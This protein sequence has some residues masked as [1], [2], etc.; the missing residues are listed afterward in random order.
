M[1]RTQ[2]LQLGRARHLLAHLMAVLALWGAPLEAQADTFFFPGFFL[3]EG[4]S[5]DFHREFAEA[6]ERPRGIAPV[7]F[8][9]T[10]DIVL[11]VGE[12][13]LVPVF[14]QTAE[15]LPV[16][17]RWTLE[18]NI[19]RSV[20]STIDKARPHALNGVTLSSHGFR[21]LLPSEI[22]GPRADTP[23]SAG[24]GCERRYFLSNGTHFY[25]GHH[26]RAVR[27]SRADASA[28]LCLHG[29]APG[30]GQV[31][32]G[33]SVLAQDLDRRV[34]GETDLLRPP[35]LGRD[36]RAAIRVK[37][38]EAAGGV[39][40]DEM[41]MAEAVTDQ[42][43]LNACRIRAVPL[44]RGG[45][46]L[47]CQSG[48]FEVEWQYSTSHYDVVGQPGCTI[49]LTPKFLPPGT[50]RAFP[51]G[52]Q[53]NAVVSQVEERVIS[54]ATGPATTVKT[55]KQA[56]AS[57]YLHPLAEIETERVKWARAICPPVVVPGGTFSCLISVV[58]DTGNPPGPYAVLPAG[59]ILPPGV[60]FAG[61][62]PRNGNYACFEVDAAAAEGTLSRLNGA[63]D[64]GLRF[65]SAPLVVSR[66][67]GDF[68]KGTKPQACP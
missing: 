23:V 21:G 34:D 1:A 44:N 57:A 62:A 14:A 38:V 35:Y 48:A 32:V 61:F 36:G 49:E 37:V 19:A 15:G 25:D 33:E 5:S 13:V 65:A 3:A 22:A 20:G 50:E 7:I 41:A 11:E 4:G 59:W 9:E 58:S 8:A 17:I 45:E 60:R 52:F 68:L 66:G 63:L 24:L 2:T 6:D 42:C 64:T 43:S 29:R 31:F 46:R 67:Y 30:E 18:N 56:F 55:I 54:N 16:P 10:D 12:T 28:F 40:R 27:P 39:L 53:V 51:R 47:D 26:R